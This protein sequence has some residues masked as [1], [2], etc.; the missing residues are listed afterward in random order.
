M[1]LRVHF[2]GKNSL[3]WFA[4]ACAVA[5]ALIALLVD[6]QHLAGLRWQLL[7]GALGV[8]AVVAL[9]VQAVLQSKED[10]DREQR[11]AKRDEAQQGIQTQLIQLSQLIMKGSQHQLESEK[12]LSV[13]TSAEAVYPPVDFD[14]A[15]YFLSA[16]QSVW[17]ADVEMRMKSVAARYYPVSGAT[18]F[19]AKFIGIGLVAYAHDIT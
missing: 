4:G 8:L 14:P 3:S 9:A 15:K 7:I 10:H 6:P 5:L 18:D 12:S 2:S 13:G 16:H 1:V 17:T 11:E 19:Y